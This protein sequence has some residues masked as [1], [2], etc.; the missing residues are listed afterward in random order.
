MT[1][2]APIESTHA[3]SAASHVSKWSAKPW[4]G[5]SL[6]PKQRQQSINSGFYECR[7]PRPWFMLTASAPDMG[8]GHWRLGE[9]GPQEDRENGWAS[10]CFV[11]T[12]SNCTSLDSSRAGPRELAVFQS[13][14][15]CG[16]IQNYRNAK[17]NTMLH[18][19]TPAQLGG[20][21]YL[22]GGRSHRGSAGRE[23]KSY[24]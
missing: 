9:Q 11:R 7:F 8:A 14:N 22:H 10:T 18:S 20:R 1:F 5:W 15:V 12:L 23:D 17:I 19:S 24:E 13:T 4:K 16:T 21:R 2:P 3:S 6:H